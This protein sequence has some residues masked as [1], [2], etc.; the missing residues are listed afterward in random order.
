M[1]VMMM[2]VRRAAGLPVTFATAFNYFDRAG[3]ALLAGLL[4]T[5]L[6]Y[7]GMILLIIPGIYLAVAYYMTIPLLG[8]RELSAWQ[9]MEASRK[10]VSKRWFRVAGLFLVT[11][12]VVGLSALPLGIGLVWTMPWALLVMG[13]LYKRMF[14]VASAA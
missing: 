13:V 2:A 5:L 10:A 12:V 9:A 4:V 1:G 8:D 11:A 3:S 6:M 7:V 14:G